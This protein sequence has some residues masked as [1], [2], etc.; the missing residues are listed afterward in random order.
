MV[1][2]SVGTIFFNNSSTDFATSIGTSSTTSNSFG[3]TFNPAIGWF[4]NENVAVGIMPDINYSKQKQTG[5]SSTGNTYLKNEN[6]QFNIGVGGFARYYFKGRSEKTRLFGQ[7]QLLVGLGGTKTEGFQYETLGVYVDR[8]DRK[9]SGDFFAKTG[10]NLGVS[11]FISSRTA[12]DFYVGYTFSYSKSNPT[13]TS[14][15]D[16]ANP[17][18]PDETQKIN[19]DQKVTGNNVVIGVGFQVFL[20][21]RK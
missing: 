5:R 7:Y 15:R 13:G 12:L 2:A 16:F 6:N 1:G 18:T 19:Y 20:D 21:K 8:Y 9:S 14:V 17:A 3:V 11:Q 10:L 4:I